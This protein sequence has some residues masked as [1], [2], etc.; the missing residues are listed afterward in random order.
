[1]NRMFR[2]VFLSSV[3][4]VSLAMS[5][6]VCAQSNDDADS[7]NKVDPAKASY[8]VGWDMA[9]RLPP[10]V[11]DEIDPDIVARAV[12]DML[13][14]KDSEIDSDEADRI[15]KAFMT[16]MKSKAKAKFDK[17][18]QKNKQK[19]QEF[20]ANNKKQS[21]VHTTDSGLQY[22]VL[23]KGSG[24]HPA[25]GDTVQVQYVGKFL[26]GKKFDASSDHPQ[27]KDGKSMPIPL[28]NVIPGFREGL[29]LMPVGSHYKFWI[30]SDLAYG[31]KP[32]N[33][34]P[35]NATIVF[36]VKLEDIKAAQSD[37]SDG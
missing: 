8:V 17:M 1:M 4:I 19:G 14:G 36:D 6:S 30:P 18:A 25:D 20:L 13:S 3:V 21:G 34:F 24:D 33:G 28:N 2:P 9:N 16:E 11:R 31:D 7:G 10:I 15:G 26:S 23:E 27:P 32:S 37:D 35:P 22:K 12:K 29:Q 5:V